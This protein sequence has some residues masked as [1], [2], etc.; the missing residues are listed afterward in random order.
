MFKNGRLARGAL[1]A[2]TLAAVASC[3][4]QEAAAPAAAPAPLAPP[5]AACHDAAVTVAQLSA[6]DKTPEERTAETAALE[7]ECQ[8]KRL[9]DAEA[10]CLADASDK[11]AAVKCPR[12][13]G[14]DLDELEAEIG[15]GK[16]RNVMLTMHLAELA[17]LRQIPP[18]QRAEAIDAFKIVKRELAHSCNNDDWGAEAMDCFAKS[19]IT[20][21]FGCIQ[22]VPPAVMQRLDARLQKAMANRGQGDDEAGPAIEATGIAACDTYLRA[23]K[24]VE[25]CAAAPPAAR[26]SILAVMRPLEA[27]WRALPPTALAA[28]GETFTGLCG[29]ATDQLGQLG[30]S[31]GCP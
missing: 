19:E 31:I 5:S 15:V 30:S 28:T 16:C 12:G 11:L 29:A 18:E 25:E 23:R 17:Q 6:P 14:H 27:P 9:S 7:A 21:A 8:K 4:S 3:K 13:L 1:C 22:Q 2:L 10:Q 20:Q 24:R 26:Q